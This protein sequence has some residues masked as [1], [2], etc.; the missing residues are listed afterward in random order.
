[1]SYF[2]RYWTFYTSKLFQLFPKNLKVIFG[3]QNW[4]IPY[5]VLLGTFAPS[6]FSSNCISAQ[7]PLLKIKISG[8]SI[9]L[10]F[11]YMIYLKNLKRNWG[12]TLRISL[13][14]DENMTAI[15]YTLWVISLMHCLKLCF[16]KNIVR[17]H[18]N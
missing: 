17:Y 3:G 7:M 6:F 1:M 18:F 10:L 16:S 15:R 8:K 13:E 2:K 5:I 14:S 4:L 9:W 12:L 11:G